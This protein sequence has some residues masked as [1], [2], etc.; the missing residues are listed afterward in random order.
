MIFK[1]SVLISTLVVYTGSACIKHP[2]DLKDRCLDRQVPCLIDNCHW[3]QAGQCMDC[4]PGYYLNLEKGACLSCSPG[5]TKCFGNSHQDCFNIENGYTTNSKSEII[6]NPIE[7]CVSSMFAD[8]DK[9]N[10]VCTMCKPG[11]FAKRGDNAMTDSYTCAKCEVDRCRYCQEGLDTCQECEEGF[12]LFGSQKCNKRPGECKRFDSELGKCLDCPQG[13]KWSFHINECVSC[14]SECQT[15]SRSGKCLGCKPGYFHQSET[16]TCTPCLVSGC[17]N[18]ADGPEYCVSCTYG[19]Y[20]DILRQKCLPCH[21][22][23]GTCNGPKAEDCSL[24]RADRKRQ[25]I[26]FTNLDSDIIKHTLDQFRMKFPRIMA[27]AAFMALNFNPQR[28]TLC[29]KE[30]RGEEYY[31][32][33][34]KEISIGSSR[35]EC[36]IANVLHHLMTN[37]NGGSYA[38][39]RLT[40]KETREKAEQVSKQKKKKQA[41]ANDD[42]LK[43][44]AFENDEGDLSVEEKEISANNSYDI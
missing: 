5:C 12:E 6:P 37:K 13:Q 18:C 11:F 3:C 41:R 40:D 23:C 44:E 17:Q 43:R 30:C 34:F 32:D 16:L 33:K 7:G 26:E 20:F 42:L 25:Q 36:P 8:N 27:Q 29:V 39:S 14:P 9:S 31:G 1:L 35:T 24:C 4:L 21:E 22:T 10:E 15:C 38:S 28:E 2:A 19:K